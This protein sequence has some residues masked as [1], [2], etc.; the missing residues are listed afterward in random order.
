VDSSSASVVEIMAPTLSKEVMIIDED[1]A[2]E[3]AVLE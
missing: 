1:S 2:I 3:L